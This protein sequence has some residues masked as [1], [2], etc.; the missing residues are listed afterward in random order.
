M[1]NGKSFRVLKPT[2]LAIAVAA[3]C[4]M[5]TAQADGRVEGRFVT[6]E[7]KLAIQGAL[8]R[9]EELNLETTTRRDGSFVFPPVKSG[10]YTMTV[11]YLGA[12]TQTRKVTVVDSQ[13]LAE[14]FQLPSTRATEHML[15]V[16]Q[17]AGIN[18]ALN[19]QR[20][21]DSII[22]VV[23][24]DAIGQLPDANA[25][26]A[27]RRVPGVS[28]EL[29]QGEGR[30]VSVRGLSPDLNSVTVNGVTVPSPSNGDRSVNLDVVPSDLLESLEVTKALTPD[31]DGNSVGGTV[32]IKSLSA[33]DR[34]DLFYKLTVEG[35]HDENTRQESPRLAATVSNIFSV[36]DG[37]DNL[38]V[39]AAV[40]WN[41]RKF[42]SENVETGGEWDFDESPATLKEV[43][44][45]DYE[46]TRE[47]LGV[48]LNLDYK[49]TGQ[50]DLYLRTLY[51]K[52][53][54]AELRQSIKAEFD[55]GLQPGTAG[56]LDGAER[57]LKDR[58][59]TQTISSFVFG[60]SS[61]RDAW[62]IDYSAGISEAKEDK[63][64][65]RETTFK[66]DDTDGDYH[67]GSGKKPVVTGPELFYTASNYKLDK[68]EFSDSETSDRIVSVKL[69]LT[70]D[71]NFDQYPG[72]IKF[73]AKATRRDK[74]ASETVFEAEDD[75]ISLAGSAGKPVDYKLGRFGPGIDPDRANAA[76]SGLEPVRDEE[77]SAVGDY[78]ISEDINAAYLMG[79][80]DIDNLRLLA[81]ARY[82]R[83]SFKTSGFGFDKDTDTV[84]ANKSSN[85]Y[86][87]LLPAVH[88]RYKLSDDLQL[89]AAWTNSVVRPT[90]EQARSGYV[91]ES[92]DEAEFGN[93]DLKAIESANLDLGIEHFIGRA[94]V[95]SAFVFYKD[96]DN[97]I[98]NTDLGGAAQFS[99]FEK[100]EI[101][102]NGKKA[103]VYGLE[104]A[105][106]KQFNELSY[107]F[108]GLLVSANATFAD[109]EAKIEGRTDGALT[110]RD[111]T[112]PGQADVTA[113]FT[114]GYE[115]DAVSLR[116]AANYKSSYLDEV[117]A[118]DK[119]HDIYVDDHT[120]L[121]FTGRYFVTDDLQ[122]FVQATN[123][124][125]EAFY[126]YTGKSSNNAQYEEYG[127]TYKLG[128]TLSN[129]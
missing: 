25:A 16:G 64:D 47:R 103:Q 41:K 9:L 85:S 109:S 36:G 35:S 121:D 92:G 115:L 10:Q 69:D 66:I 114:L 83:T 56:A 118:T 113:N 111:I 48:T 81:G 7:S 45:R 73:G 89:R 20:I 124:T 84:I 51:S 27:L 107:P 80:V 88:A 95:V 82:E 8:I 116:L 49:L 58:E 68:A 93:P 96:I 33:F 59:E 17:A 11:Q 77:K 21:S 37:E 123:L 28:I 65:A 74:D 31:M 106:S 42:G 75:S 108:N 2:L 3:G 94:G 126:R 61:R 101:A 102:V 100:A 62:T 5:S 117:N 105:F 60:G 72:Q 6:E 125:D 119:R 97:F 22:S 15:V 53:K 90:F 13:I 78:D 99:D 23:N 127:R 71:L 29:D 14:Q 54:D 112:L 39:A 55:P 79:K 40:S 129:F 43:E 19:K 26:E 57:Q 38:G 34:D 87:N 76:V 86:G 12:E 24:A 32:N 50:D 122:L 98:Y 1:D 44:M 67:L 52:F 4:A 110:S 128:L 104:L 63:P 30:K 120:Q 46:I 91:K 70:R 18:R